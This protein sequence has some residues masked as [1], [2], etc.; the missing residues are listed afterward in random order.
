VLF[1]SDSPKDDWMAFEKIVQGLIGN[2]VMFK[3][4]QRPTLQQ[5]FLAADIIKEI[6]PDFFTE[7]GDE[8]SSYVAAVFAD[9]EVP[10]VPP[11]LSEI[12][13]V[14]D[15]VEEATGLD[16]EPFEADYRGPQNE[17]AS[18]LILQ[19]YNVVVSDRSNRQQ[20][21]G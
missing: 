1:V 4:M 11:P 20:E 18:K 19:S 17:P 14:Q 6:D 21:L 12:K 13:E 2:E 16:Y 8:V 9:E 5:L 3:I 10:W 15:K 7:C